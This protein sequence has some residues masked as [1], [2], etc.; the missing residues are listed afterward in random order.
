MIWPYKLAVLFSRIFTLVA[1]C[2]GK[3]NN[4]ATVLEVN[5]NM[6][7]KSRYINP[8]LVTQALDWQYLILS[9][10]KNP[11]D[12]INHMFWIDSSCCHFF[13]LRQKVF[14]YNIS[15][16]D[17]IVPTGITILSKSCSKAL[18]ST[19]QPWLILQTYVYVRHNNCKPSISHNLVM[20]L[21]SSPPLSLFS[22]T[23]GDEK[24]PE[25]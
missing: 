11:L 2:G 16:S 1:S 9:S 13:L 22:R 21:L 17:C 24:K 18:K 15:S 19:Q 12:H 3:Q 20:P 6:S 23:V 4:F 25:N 14:Q 8:D 10:P 5:C 7:S